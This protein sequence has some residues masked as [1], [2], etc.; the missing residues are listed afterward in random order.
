MRISLLPIDSR[1]CTYE[2]PV[3]LAG[4]AGVEIYTPPMTIMDQFKIPSGF[5]DIANWLEEQ[6]AKTDVLV[7]S[8]E[9]LLHGGLITSRTMNISREEC[10][11]RLEWIKNL[12][13]KYKNLEIHAFNII[14]RTSISTLSA[15]SK[16]WWEKI[17]AY[18]RA[19]YMENS[20]GEHK[21]TVQIQELAQEIPSEVLEEFLEARQRNNAVNMECLQLVKEDIF[22]SL[23]LLQ[24]DSAPQGI[25]RVEQT[26]LCQFISQFKLEQKVLL[27]NGTD[28]AACEI[29][30][31][32]ISRNKRPIK[33]FINW[34][35]GNKDKFIALYE[36]RLFIENLH[37]HMKAV[38][39]V[40]VASKSDAD[41]IVNVFLPKNQQ[42]DACICFEALCNG[43]TDEELQH[44]AHIISQ[45]ITDGRPTA[46]LDLA[47]ANGGDARILD[48][49]A[50]KVSL[51][52]LVAYSGWNTASNAL[53][54]LLSQ[55][56]L[57]RF[58]NSIKNKQFTAERLMDDFIY[59]SCV[60]PI[61]EKKLRDNG[62]DC[63]N[64]S[65]IEYAQTI[66]DEAFELCRPVMEKVF[67]D[68]VPTFQQKLRWHRTFEISIT[69][70]SLSDMGG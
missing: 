17:N 54:T 19:K 59:Q 5:N 69:I 36:D 34:L 67:K 51:L 15:Q 44:F 57:S 12:K 11:R 43:Y 65:D 61:A 2:F 58:Y 24:E 25:H 1:P 4:I 39:L 21:Y 8:V 64:I 3:R 63:W 66:V 30:A 27:H 68:N 22:S 38:G 7:L 31:R 42:G 33:V 32:I 10:F 26:Q 56:C 53:G 18:S 9:Q 13:K 46:L 16:V 62:Q 55:I 70:Q 20:T 50:K 60:R 35:G 45:D 14:M 37:S 29:I 41:G 23:L 40:E 47:Y 49:L 6:A 48:A 52:E 28:E